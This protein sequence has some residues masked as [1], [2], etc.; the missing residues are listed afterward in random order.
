MHQLRFSKRSSWAAASAV[1]GN[2][3]EMQIRGPHPRA[4]EPE[5]LQVGTQPSAF[6]P[7]GPDTAQVGDLLV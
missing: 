1:V 3:L 5:T 6:P 4:T 2:L 7:G